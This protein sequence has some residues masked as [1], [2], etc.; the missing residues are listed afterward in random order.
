[1]AAGEVRKGGLRVRLQEQPLRLLLLLLERPGEIVTREEVR[2]A[3]WPADT[4]V[5]FDHSLATALAK[6]RTALGDSARSPRFIQTVAGR[7]YKFVAPAPPG[8]PPPAPPSPP[9]GRSRW[10]ASTAAFGFLAAGLLLAIVLGPDLFGA[11]A[12][13]R[14]ETNRP[15]GSLVV[16][17][18]QNLSSDASQEYFADSMTAELI[19]ALAELEGI[20]LISRTS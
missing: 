13:L 10:F 2:Q 19:T 12:W 16:L 1:V 9:A 14:R 7:G 20:Q 15:V 8:E 5:D 17:P 18:L 11:R 6:L 3:L 4:F